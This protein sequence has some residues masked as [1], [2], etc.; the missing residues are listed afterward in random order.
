MMQRAF[1]YAK[2]GSHNYTTSKAENDKLVNLGWR[3]EGV[4]W[5]GVQ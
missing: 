5:Y 1:P 4:G 2:A 3:G